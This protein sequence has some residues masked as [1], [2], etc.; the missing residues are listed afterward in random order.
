LKTTTDAIRIITLRKFSATK[1]YF[2]T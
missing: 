1:H 2:S